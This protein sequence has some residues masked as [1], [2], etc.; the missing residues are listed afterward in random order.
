MSILGSFNI[1]KVG[2][3][4]I[5]KNLSNFHFMKIEKMKNEKPMFNYISFWKFKK[6][7]PMLNFQKRYKDGQHVQSHCSAQQKERNPINQQT[8]KAC[9]IHMSD[10]F[11]SH[12]NDKWINVSSQYVN[13]QK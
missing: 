2:K 1:L 7:K 4:K 9:Q 11:N 8:G 10:S 12:K 13:I 6:W 3:W 5:E